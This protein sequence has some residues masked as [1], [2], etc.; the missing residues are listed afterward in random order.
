MS[1]AVQTIVKDLKLKPEQVEG[2]L[3]LLKQDLP[4]AFIARYRKERCGGLDEDELAAIE[5]RWRTVSE[6]EARRAVVKNSIQ[7]LD[8]LDAALKAKLDAAATKADLEDLYLPFAPPKGKKNRAVAARDKGLEPLADLILRQEADGR[9]AEEITMPF[10]SAEKGV[11]E[12]AD[13]LSGARD[14][15]ADRIAADADIRGQLRG[16]LHAEGRLTAK[17]RDKVE[18]DKTKYASYANFSEPLEK[19]PPH[20]I[21][22]VLRGEEEKK[23]Q[24]HL[25]FPRE[26]AVELVKAKYPSRAEAV[27]SA[28]L[29]L[30]IEDA[31]TRLLL[32]QLE[33]E[34]RTGLKAR[35]DQHAAELFAKNLRALLLAPPLGRK[36]VVAAL[37][38][39]AGSGA[40]LQLA[41]LD[42]GGKLL[43][44]AEVAPWKDEV[45][46]ADAKEK[47]AVFLKAAVP[48][49]CAIGNGAGGREAGQFLKDALEAAGF[50]AVPRIFVNEA[51]AAAY[52]G[53]KTGKHELPEA[54]NNLRAAVFLGRRLQDPLAELVKVDP[55]SIGV[56]QYQ[57]DVDARILRKKLD[58]AFAC[59]V[60]RVGVDL[61]AAGPDVLAHVSGIGAQLAQAVIET[62]AKQGGFKSR[63]EL[64]A[65]PGLGEKEFMLAAGFLRVRD[66]VN[67]LD[68]T[69]IHP[70]RYALVEA[71]AQSA[72]TDAKGL[73]GNAA[74][75]NKL[76]L[77]AFEAADLG[78]P[79]LRDIAAELKA[80][81]A[82]PRGAF[83]PPAFSE[84][85]SDIKDLRE[86]QVLNGV[87]TNITAF[88]VFVDLGVRQDGLVHISEL[89]HRFVRDPASAF[90]V[91]QPVKVKVLGVDA[92]KKRISLSIKALE[93]PPPPRAERA[94]QRER[95]PRRPREGA[96]AGAA[97]AGTPGA[98]AQGGERRPRR[99]RGPRPAGVPAASGAG[100]PGAPGSSAATG[101]G[102]PGSGGG[103]RD[104]GRRGER[105]GRGEK[106][107]GPR[108]SSTGKPLPDYSKFFVKGGKKKDKKKEE[109]TPEAA[110]SRQEVREV[111]K[112]QAS[113]SAPTLADLLKQAGVDS[114][115][116]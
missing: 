73:L 38:S 44:H 72:G 39:G 75:V 5:E 9:S 93:T 51:G 50:G 110:A 2:A 37:A 16:L 90:A 56:G 99:E 54:D 26:K 52:G 115:E 53:S 45:A 67:P 77:K 83:V 22:A 65:V 102:R 10:L 86:G 48:E 4:A 57:H 68:A 76:D 105:D 41:A 59:C 100:G 42:A 20:R 71:L 95:G 104:G 108:V 30:S 6:L 94:P 106:P 87:V 33:H 18:L 47:T 85:V 11:K 17:G 69:A 24:L 27:F 84:E 116:E 88:G 35:A 55:K 66:G 114:K 32:P 28:E 107:A 80:P 96:P 91:G 82:D 81:G 12:L 63:E 7:A 97:T 101:A 34:I 43:A 113:R 36:P 14:L 21:Q 49:A 40:K 78:L 61:N 111:L 109:K 13:A 62:R 103:R 25:E 19:L 112:G 79:T 31:L 8:K 46:G 89:S 60:N 3:A 64:K 1:D 23:L 70:E 29:A 74:A 92:G 98:P 15:I 58:E